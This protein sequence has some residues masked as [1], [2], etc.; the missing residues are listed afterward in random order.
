MW[1]KFLHALY[2]CLHCQL[3]ESLSKKCNQNNIIIKITNFIFTLKYNI[4]YDLGGGVDRK[5]WLNNVFCMYNNNL[6]DLITL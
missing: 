5:Q 1:Y 6:I 4:L 3:L 2:K